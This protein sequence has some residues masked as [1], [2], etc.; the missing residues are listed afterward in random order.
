MRPYLCFILLLL[1]LSRLA[2]QSHNSSVTLSARNAPL[3]QILDTISNQTGFFFSYNSAIIPSGSLYTIE[4][5]KER[6][7]RFLDRLLVGTRLTYNFSGDQIILKRLIEAPAKLLS[8]PSEFIISGWARDEDTG[9]VIPGVNVYLDGTSIGA[10][11]NENGFYRFNNV[12]WGRYELVFSHV[13]F[14]KAHFEVKVQ[15]HDGVTVNAQ[16]RLKTNQLGGIEVASTR[17]VPAEDWDKTYRIFEREFF[18]NTLNSARCQILNPRVLEFYTDESGALFAEASAPLRIRNEALGY[19]IIYEL[20]RFENLEEGLTYY[21][22][23]RFEQL[24]VMDSKDRKRWRR[25][26]KK[27]YQGSLRHFL[28]ALSQDNLRKEGFRL[29]KANAIV[30]ISDPTPEQARVEDVLVK[31][32]DL[33]WTLSFENYL[34]VEYYKEKES[35]LYLISM[36][37]DLQERAMLSRDNI[38][39]LTRK[40]DVQRSLLRLKESSVVI[41]ANGHIRKPLGVSTIGYWAWER[42]ADIVPIDYDPKNRK[43]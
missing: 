9:D 42:F 12:P 23:V 14:D 4:A 7:T 13:S 20:E 31:N 16:L 18:G 36:T 30:T 25:A 15:G 27:S 32:N 33:S 38:L 28:K 3:E 22:N 43:L 1:A 34:Y 21:G 40:P 29:Y 10:V 24:P 41:D 37:S 19:M 39:F 8:R 11:T 5:D 35:E 17:L 2:A 6:L 26:R